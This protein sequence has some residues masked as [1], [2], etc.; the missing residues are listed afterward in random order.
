M[1]YHY[2]VLVAS[3][4]KSTRETLARQLNKFGYGVVVADSGTEVVERLDNDSFDLVLLDQSLPDMDG[5]ETFHSIKMR[6]STDHPP[7]IMITAQDSLNWAMKFMQ[8]Q[9]NDY[10]EQPFDMGILDSKIRRAITISNVYRGFE[11]EEKKLS[12]T[13]TQL[14]QVTQEAQT[15]NQA[16]SEFLSIM[17]HELRTPLHGILSFATFGIKKYRSESPD[18]LLEYFK[19]IEHCGRTLLQLL[20]DLLDLAKL[21]SG[22]MVFEFQPADFHTLVESI[23]QEFHALSSERKITITYKKPKIPH[24]LNLDSMRITQVL[25]NLLSNAIKFSLMN[26]SVEIKTEKLHNCLRVSVIDNGIGIPENELELVFQKFTQSSKTQPI[27][28]GSGLGLRICQEILAGHNGRIWAR[29]NAKGGST[30]TFELPVDLV[31]GKK[32][33]KAMSE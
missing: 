3:K 15:A 19:Q 23:L 16:K 11:Q 31:K 10:V 14:E 33:V 5:L 9:G 12:A 17:S 4:T 24:T 21:E 6:E 13:I 22:K 26:G 25:R 20:N 2:K 28:G 32:I 18:R 30:F 27:F 1:K 7:V 8:A 29:N